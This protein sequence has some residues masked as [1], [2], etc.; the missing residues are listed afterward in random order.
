MN[1]Q[2]GAFLEL[3]DEIPYKKITYFRATSVVYKNN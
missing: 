3:P 1:N 2:Q